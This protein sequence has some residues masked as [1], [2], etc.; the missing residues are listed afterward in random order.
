MEKQVKAMYEQAMKKSETDQTKYAA[1]MVHAFKEVLDLIE[2]QKKT[3]QDI[4]NTKHN[5]YAKVVK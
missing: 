5:R 1:G 2:A 4:I 3:E